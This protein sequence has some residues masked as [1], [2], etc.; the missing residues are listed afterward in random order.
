M[1]G[2]PSVW[3]TIRKGIQA[4]VRTSPP[5]LRFAFGIAFE[6]KKLLINLGLPSGFL[7]GA[8]QKIK[9]STGGRLRGAVSGGNN[10]DFN[11]F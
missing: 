2:V 8:F 10:L 11:E 5:L 3:E 9:H 6:A 1:A 7:D 4:K